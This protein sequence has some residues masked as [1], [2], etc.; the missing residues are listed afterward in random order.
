[1]AT[2]RARFLESR[3]EVLRTLQD[4]LKSRVCGQAIVLDRLAAAVRRRELEL[5]PKLGRERCL[6]FAGPTGVGKTETAKALAELLFGPESLHRF[7]CG[8]FRTAEAVAALLGNREGDRGRFGQ[9]FAAVPQGV[10]LFDELEKAHPEFM[11]LLMAMTDAGRLTLASGETLDLS[12][13]YLVATSNLGCAE[14]LGRQHLPF[15]TLEKHVVRSI[16]RHLRPELVARFMSPLVFRPLDLETQMRVTA[17]HLRRHI[18]SQARR[19]LQVEAGPEVLRF[20]VQVGCGSKLGARPL[21]DAIHQHVGDALA[22]H[23]LWGGSGRGRLVV[24][25]RELRF[26][27]TP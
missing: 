6:I 9:A 22:Q 14:I 1:M 3:L 11:P 15:T 13:L 5:V 27:E 10:W 20:L 7:D 8:E 18:E 4:E 23:V 25:G 16:H 21:I 2:R 19:G 17:L 24:V 12:G 26:V